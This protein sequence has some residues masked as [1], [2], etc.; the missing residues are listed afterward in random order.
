MCWPLMIGV[1][2]GGMAVLV[3]GLALL[4]AKV[5][6]SFEDDGIPSSTRRRS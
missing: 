3:A 4:L 6:V 2:V 5:P 1:A